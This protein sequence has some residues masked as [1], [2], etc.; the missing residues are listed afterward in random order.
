MRADRSHCWTPPRE[1]F[2]R[3]A[4]IDGAIPVIVVELSSNEVPVEGLF[5][6]DGDEAVPALFRSR[7]FRVWAGATLP[8]TS[9]WMAR[10]SITNTFGGF[11]IVNPFRIVGQGAGLA[12][13]VADG[14]QRRF[15]TLSE[16][17]GQKIERQ[18]TGRP[19]RLWKA[20]HELGYRGAAHGPAERDDPG[21]VWPCTGCRDID[22]LRRLQ[23][24]NATLG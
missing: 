15:R 11:P 19:S 10:F 6:V 23:E 24:L 18:L 14:A 20:A 12:A 16:E 9:S 5:I 2:R 3:Y 1:G 13:L 4:L 22:I 7:V 21:M 8:T 17:V